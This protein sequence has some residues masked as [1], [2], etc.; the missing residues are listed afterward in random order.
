MIIARK[1]TA[2]DLAAIRAGPSASDVPALLDEIEYTDACLGE[3]WTLLD[4]MLRGQR[5]LSG[6][7]ARRIEELLTEQGC[8]GYEPATI[9]TE[10]A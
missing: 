9:R 3:C 10:T 8:P 1:L 4:E 2:D 6:G 5:P 7:F